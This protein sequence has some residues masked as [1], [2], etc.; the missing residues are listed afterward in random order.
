MKSNI[1]IHVPH[2]SMYIPEEYKKTALIPVEELEAENRFMCDT[3]I[4]E[5]IPESMKERMKF[6]ENTADA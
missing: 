4:Q 5:L 1:L 6:S 2:A 3:G